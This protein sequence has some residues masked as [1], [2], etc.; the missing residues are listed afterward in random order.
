[1]MSSPAAPGLRQPAPSISFARLGNLVCAKSI[2]AEQDFVALRSSSSMEPRSDLGMDA[3]D[4]LLCTSGVA[5]RAEGLP[6]GRHRAVNCWKKCSMPLD[7]R[8][9]VEHHAAH[10]AP[11]QARPQERAVSTSALTTPPQR[12]IDLAAQRRLQT[13]ATWPAFPC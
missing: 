10:N 1:M 7:R 11:A 4:E 13:V 5:R 2:K 6:P 9:V 12:V 8:R 3:V